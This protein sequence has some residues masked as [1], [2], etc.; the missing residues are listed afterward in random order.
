LSKRCPERHKQQHPE[1]NEDQA[2]QRLKVIDARQYRVVLPEE[3]LVDDR[4]NNE[5][6]CRDRQRPPS[7]QGTDRKRD[8]NVGGD[9]RR[10]GAG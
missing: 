2:D 9:Q 1:Q 3:R 6:R 10:F 4:D 5:T 7:A 8:Q